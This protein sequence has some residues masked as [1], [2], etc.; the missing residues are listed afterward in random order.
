MGAIDRVRL[1][2]ELRQVCMRV[3]RRARFDTAGEVAPHQFSVLAKVE[4]EPMT[5]R[6]LA[7]TEAVSGP[8]MSRTISCLTDL[9][10]L[11]REQDPQDGR[12]SWLYLTPSGAQAL[13]TTRARRDQWMLARVE[14]LSEQECRVL[15]QAQAILAKVVVK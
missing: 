2:A 6:Q 9:G 8:S 13:E 4:K 1:A 14:E 7:Q 12:Q 11:R 15:D 5:P 10:L 3:S